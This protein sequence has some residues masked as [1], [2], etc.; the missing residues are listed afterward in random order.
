MFFSIKLFNAAVKSY[1]DCAVGEFSSILAFNPKLSCGPDLPRDRD[2]YAECRQLQRRVQRLGFRGLSSHL[3]YSWPKAHFRYGL[4]MGTLANAA[5]NAPRTP[6]PAGAA[7][8]RLGQERSQLLPD[9]RA[10]AQIERHTFLFRDL[11]EAAVDGPW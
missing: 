1:W 3:P 11:A 8:L 6:L 10:A 9:C 2:E 7:K 4:A 5:R